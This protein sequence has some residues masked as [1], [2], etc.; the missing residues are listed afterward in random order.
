MKQ[1]SAISLLFLSLIAGAAVTDHNGLSH[2]VNPFIGASTSIDAAGVYH[3]LGKTFPGAATPFGMA[4]V[5]PNTI[6]GGDN[7]PGYSD[8]HRTIEG[9]AF[10]QMSGI[11]WYGDLGNLL[12]MPTTGR[13]HTIAGKEDG[14]LKGWRS[15]YDKGSEKAS[16]GYY[17]AR[18]TD[19]DILAETTASPHGGV[20][21]FTY[22]ENKS[23][24]IQIDLSR[25][26]GGCSDR[27]CVKVINDHTV[28]G[29]MLCTPECGG[30]GDGGGNARYT[31][32]FH[33]EFSKPFSRYGF[34]S[35][36]IPDGWSRHNR[37]VA[38]LKYQK[39]AGKAK[40]IRGQSE[41]E[42][43]HIGFFAEF[44]TAA[45]EQVCMY[46]AISF[47]DI[48]GARKNFAAELEGRTFDDIHEAAVAMWDKE[49]SKVS[50]EGGSDD[51]RTIFYTAL[52]HTMIDPRLY[53]DVDGRYVGG[54]YKIHHTGDAFSKRT[55]FS[56]WDVFR[57]QMPLNTITNPQVTVDVINS[58]TALAEES[59]RGYYERWEFLNAYSGCMLGNPAIS[60]ITDAW[61]KGIR[62]FDLRKAYEISKNTSEKIGNSACG[63]TPGSISSTLENAYTDWCVSILADACGDAEGRNEYIAKGQAYRN[64]FD[65]ETGWF[66]PRAEDG[67]YKPL[68]SDGRYTEGYGC[69]E[70]NPF[71]QGWFVPHDLGGLAG[72]IGG[73]DKVLEELDF[74]F[75]RTPLNFQWNQYYNHANE[76]VHFVPFLYNA[77]GEPYKT[78]KWTRT[79]CRNAYFNAVEGLCG[80]EDCG[81][82][83]AWYILAASGLHPLC[84]GSTRM[85]ITSPM[86]DRVEFKLDPVYHKGEKFIIIAHD[87]SDTNLYIQRASLNGRPLDNC[88]LDFLDISAGGT[89]ELWMGAEPSGWGVNDH[90]L[91]VN[92]SD[93]SSSCL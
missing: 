39:Q 55:I 3:G 92:D 7:G 87:N 80:N 42:G 10:T 8:E 23:S 65:V 46:A 18:L 17:S 62:A 44:P 31:I 56:G 49:L 68:P 30:W 35:A 63:Y 78:Q 37:D 70:S 88:F 61:V 9:F 47:V 69:A 72:L 84:P 13:L 33:A 32:Y 86:F 81:Q 40:V 29:W 6:T 57:S 12:T 58:L 71:Q 51:D 54:D 4:Q 50:V 26:V 74:M 91:P 79:I 20:L 14:S 24:R 67:S 48:E 34:W 43:K 93:I 90:C 1:L 25:R 64:I 16:A 85:E 60:V 52:Y 75:S 36:N 28:E 89:L 38:S 5:S 2:Y 76:P 73:R 82:M 11:G 41:I 19:Y 66:R 45:S 15:F 83:S 53:S 77:F 22:P 21:R 59:G 27:Q